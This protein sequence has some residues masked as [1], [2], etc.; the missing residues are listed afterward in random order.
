MTT[1][2]PTPCGDASRSSSANE[3]E[4]AARRQAVQDALYRIA[5]AASAVEDLPAFYATVHGI[6]GG[7]MDAENFYIALYD[8]RAPARSTSPTTW[9]RSTRTSRTRRLWEPMGVGRGRRHDGV[10]PAHRQT[11]CSSTRPPTATSSRA[12]RSRRSAS[13]A[14]A[15]GSGRRSSPRAETLGVIV[16]QTYDADQLHTEDDRDL[17]AFVGQHIGSALSRARAI[18]ETRQRNAELALVNE[19]GLALGQPAGVRRDHR[20]RRRTTARLVRCPVDVHR[21]VRRRDGARSRSR[22]RSTRAS[23]CRPRPSGLARA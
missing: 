9:T 20:A 4:H 7:L 6:V 21:H 16:V 19:I 8:D 18:E 2:D 12:A 23:A 15:T 5:E 17:L 14:R 22:T 3:T 13:S 1:D 11:G 10:R